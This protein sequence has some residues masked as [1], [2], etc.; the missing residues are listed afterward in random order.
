MIARGKK[1]F[2]SN[3]P[4]SPQFAMTTFKDTLLKDNF[5]L[6]HPFVFLIHKEKPSKRPILM[7]SVL[8]ILL[9]VFFF[10]T[11]NCVSAQNL[12]KQKLLYIN[13]Y[14]KGYKWSD[15][16]EK[17]LLKAL[18]VTT[19]ADGSYDFSKSTVDLK[20]FRMD[21]KN[22]K[23]E[24]FKK[25]KANI[26]KL[27]IEKWQPDIVVASDDNASKY[28]IAPN[29]KNSILP[30]VFCGVNWDA[31]VYGFPT[32]NI[33]GMVEISPVHEL[34]KMLKQYAR[35]E[36]LSY[37]G[38]STLS[39]KKNRDHFEK[40]LGRKFS[41]GKLI[42]NFDEWKQVYLSLQDS[43]DM[44][45]WLNPVGIRGWN[46]EKAKEFILKH[47]KIPTGSM[48][49]TDICYTL[50]G[51]VG[52]AE[53]QGWWAGKTALKILNG[54]LP[55]DIPVTTN[56]QSKLYLNMELAK[57]MGIKFPIELIVQG[58]FVEDQR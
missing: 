10:T 32:S 13:S 55:G 7:R 36:R 33:T 31:S 57:Q 38:D 1:N 22:H 45:I 21:T 6:I 4:N 24:S 19:R 51:K 18:Q 2:L 44:L 49:D 50:L 16:I 3:I 39:T 5:T 25:Q 11:P 40:I 26:A 23:A 46:V 14:H 12:P 42:E 8:V 9:T 15:D 54:T 47:T 17:G 20:V 37:I 56:K 41:T 35:G 27:L 29:F 53:E 52:I 30:I 43:S 34:V 28:L 58:A 48:G